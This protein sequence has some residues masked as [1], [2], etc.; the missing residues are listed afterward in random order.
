MHNRALYFAHGTNAQYCTPPSPPYLT[1]L[2]LQRSLLGPHWAM[3][4]PSGPLSVM[5]RV[6][7][8]PTSPRVVAV[9]RELGGLFFVCL[10]KP[11]SGILVAEGCLFLRQYGGGENRPLFTHLSVEPAPRVQNHAQPYATNCFI[12]HPLNVWK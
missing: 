3:H 8:P 7:H 4:E 1:V 5:H 6:K 10:C 12:S 11:L 2:T 9:S